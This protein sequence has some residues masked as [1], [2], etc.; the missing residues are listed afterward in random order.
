[1]IDWNNR[2]FLEIDNDWRRRKIKE[3]LY[4]DSI[5]RQMEI[6]PRKLMN[7][8]KGTDI[9]DCWKEFYHHI[10]QTFETKTS[11][12]KPLR[13]K[14]KTS[15]TKTNQR[16]YDITCQYLGTLGICN[17]AFSFLCCTTNIIADEKE[18]GKV[19]AL[20][21]LLLKLPAEQRNIEF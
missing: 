15:R 11:Q 17:D 13:S 6:N 8:E 19:E 14:Q 10:R 5:N 4:I 1:M 2:N 21:S 20:V 16:K 9:S 3:A 7:P 12:K 18:L